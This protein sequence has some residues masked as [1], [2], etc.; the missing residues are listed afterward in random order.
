[1]FGLMVDCRVSLFATLARRNV[2]FV[3]GQRCDS[4]SPRLKLSWLFPASPL[5]MSQPV[6]HGEHPISAAESRLCVGMPWFFVRKG[7]NKTRRRSEESNSV[8]V[9]QVKSSSARERVSHTLAKGFYPVNWRPEMKPLYRRLGHDDF[10]TS[11]K[12]GKWIVPGLTC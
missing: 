1:M 4:M 8:A 7:V 5:I 10:L 2:Q 11:S 9:T 3:I 6:R 12:V